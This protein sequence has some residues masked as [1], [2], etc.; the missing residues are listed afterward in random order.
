ME[1]T[2]TQALPGDDQLF[3]TKEAARYLRVSHRTVEDWRFKGGG[4]RFAYA[5][6]RIV[7]RLS[8]LDGFLAARTF[9]N[10]G[11]AKMALRHLSQSAPP[12]TNNH[13]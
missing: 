12:P 3:T 9:G 7:Y 6:G 5:G 13:S 8:D 10:T 11:E 1:N 4:P 2:S